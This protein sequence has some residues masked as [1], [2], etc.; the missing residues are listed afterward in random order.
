MSILTEL[1]SGG[2]EG[3]L[4]GVDKLAGRFTVNKDLAEA[5]THGEQIAASEQVAA[6]YQYRGERT[7]FDAVIDGVNRL[8][9]PLIAFATLGLVPWCI[10]DPVGFSEAMQALGLMPEWLSLVLMQVIALFFG[11]RMLEKWN[12]TFKG[13][14]KAEVQ[15][16]IG[17]IKELHALTLKPAAEADTRID[18][19]A[20][21]Q[22]MADT[23]TPLSNAAIAE[24]NRRRK[25]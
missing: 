16:V 25:G 14:T 10:A 3:I 5:N 17:N 23:A 4:T 19:A 11:G 9:R 8:P 22:Q 15:Q 2:A 21:Q 13:P 1:V 7:G 18:D 20:Y 24:W 6:E 12:G